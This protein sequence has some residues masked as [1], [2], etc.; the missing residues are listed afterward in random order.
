MPMLIREKRMKSY[1]T[2][3]QNGQNLYPFQ[4]KLTAQK[5]IL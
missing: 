5:H 4:T 2:S 3:N 1:P